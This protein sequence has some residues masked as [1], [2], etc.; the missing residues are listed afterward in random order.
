MREVANVAS[1]VRTLIA[2][3]F[4]I[5]DARR[6]SQHIEILCTRRDLLDV[7]VHY[8]IAIFDVDTPSAEVLTGVRQAATR[9]NRSVVFVAGSGSPECIAWSDFLRALG[10]EV[11][12]WRALSTDYEPILINSAANTLPVGLSGEAWQIFEDATADGFEFLLGHRVLRLGSKA[13]GKRVSD[14]LALT[15]DYRIY[16]LD[17]KASRHPFDGSWP[18]LRALV[19]YTKLQI[20]RQRAEWPV[21]GALIVAADFSQDDVSL[22]ATAS[23][24]LAETGMP[25]GYLKVQ[26]LAAAIRALTA[27]P[28][29]RQ[30]IS[31]KRVFGR[32]GSVSESAF[33]KELAAARAT[34][35]NRK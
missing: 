10:G 34:Q 24:F 12:T 3:G 7:D 25:L 20:I 16:V 2:S 26:V 6:Q 5:D 27:E 13:R 18:N 28:R 33:E 35:Y 11:P 29:L 4:L 9:Q 8:L 14:M 21:G 17:S 19:E 23:E 31:W 30:A 15:P 22:A 32:G 1:A